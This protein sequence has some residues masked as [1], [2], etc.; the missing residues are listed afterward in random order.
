MPEQ[1]AAARLSSP[2]S[3]QTPWEHTCPPWRLDRRKLSDL[4]I[5]PDM[6]RA[7]AGQIDDLAASIKGHGLLVPVLVEPDGT[8]R[9]GVRRL[10][11]L[12][13]LGRRE[14][15]CLI[16]PPGTDT[17]LVQLVE[18]LQR[19][20]L[21]PVDEARAFRRVLDRTGW[22]QVRLARE[23]SV[24]EAHVSLALSMLDAPPEVLESVERGQDSAYAVQ[25]AFSKAGRR[26]GRAERIRQ[27]VHC[28]NVVPARFCSTGVRVPARH[29]PEGVR[30][31]VFA[32]R[33]QFTFTARE[34]A[35][36]LSKLNTISALTKGLTA[37][38]D[39]ALG[40]SEPERIAA[41]VTG[42]N[43]ARS[44]ALRMDGLQ[45]DGEW[46][47]SPTRAT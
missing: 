28:G 16:I 7:E 45:D 35:F 32:D 21:S 22:K 17:A 3:A 30:A 13:S 20:D 29:L 37:A 12:K 23:L 9:G 43:E 11:A 31:R 2:K 14:A 41:L 8:V 4:K 10:A 36:P 6:P 26:D 25:C 19:T 1:L 39:A 18:N 44:K 27:R 33:I 46:E 15:E 5:P 34:R 38:L 42:L 24:S 47:G 40:S